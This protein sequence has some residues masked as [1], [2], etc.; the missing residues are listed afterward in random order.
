M[1]TSTENNPQLSNSPALAQIPEEYTPETSAEQAP[2]EREGL[3]RDEVQAEPELDGVINI[4][5]VDLALEPISGLKYRLEIEGK[6]ISGVTDATGHTEQL[7]DIVAGTLIDVYVFRDHLKDY[8]KVGTICGN[9]GECGYSIVSPKLRFALDTEPHE[10]T[11]GTAEENK[12]LIP[13]VLTQEAQTAS[14]TTAAP[15]VAPPAPVAVGLPP[16]KPPTPGTPTAAKPAVTKLEK[17]RDSKGNPLVTVKPTVVDN[18]YKAVMPFLH[19]WGWWSTGYIAKPTGSA[20][21]KTST[22]EAKPTKPNKPNK[23]PIDIE[24]NIQAATKTSSSPEQ[25]INPAVQINQSKGTTLS[26]E[27][28]KYLDALISYAEAQVLI[29]YVKYKGKGAV[30]QKIIKAITSHPPEVNPAKNATKTLGM[31]FAYVRVALH[32]NRL[33]NADAGNGDAK[34]AG[35]DLGK[36]GYQNVTDTL[37]QVK[38]E[39]PSGHS[40]PQLAK[41]EASKRKKAMIEAQATKEKWSPKQKNEAL[42][43]AET[44]PEPEGVSYTQADL[45]YTLPGDIIVY[46]QVVPHDPNAA[47]HIDIRTYHGFMSDFV[48]PMMPKLGGKKTGGK[49]YAVIGVYRKVSDEMAMVRVKAFLKIV[50]EHETKGFSDTDSYFVLP[51]GRD[52]QTKKLM[53]RKFTS[54]STHPFS[55]DS[56][57]EYDRKDFYGNLN[58][59]GGAYQIKVKTWSETIEAMGWHKQFDADMQTRIAIYRL[60]FRSNKEEGINRK[61]ALGYLMQGD[62][63][64]V[65]DETNLPDEWSWLPGGK[66]ANITIADLKA[67]F[68]AHIKDMRK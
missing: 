4:D 28:K 25:A 36:E 35:I 21:T 50:R 16:A 63:E 10:G 64:K 18:V 9:G 59:S 34:L 67:K 62:I 26:P 58:T 41:L 17:G 32:Q 24:K 68:E 39:Y 42:Q 30:S 57:V 43:Q 19:L 45:M 40:E 51:D 29:N 23:K 22:T 60:Q 11:P 33:V 56:P 27:N 61:S 13:P 47:G 14:A 3:S 2:N 52:P 12:P 53:K 48:W 66:Q 1:N 44:N 37:P 15:S 38:I 65:V 55:D 54:N 8:K 7:T 31:C 6:R 5:F 20:Q 46:K 49:Q